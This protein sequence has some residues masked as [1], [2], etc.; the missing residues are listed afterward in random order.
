MHAHHDYTCGFLQKSPPPPNSATPFSGHL[1]RVFLVLITSR[2]DIYQQDPRPT[3]KTAIHSSFPFDRKTKVLDCCDVYSGLPPYTFSVTTNGNTILLTAETYDDMLS[4]LDAIRDCLEHQAHILRGVLWKKSARRPQQPWTQRDVELGHVS[5]TYVST[6]V[7]MEATRGHAHVFGIS[8]GES[9]IT[10]GAPSAEIKDKWLKEIEI[11]IAKQRIQRRVFEKPT[12]FAGFVDVRKAS[13]SKWRRRFVELERGALAFKTDQR[14]VGM[15]TRVPLE[16]ITA[17]IATPPV[18]ESG[19]SL[20]F[21]IERFGAVTL[22]LAAFSA[23]EKQ[24]WLTKL[25]MARRDHLQHEHLPNAPA[26]YLFPEAMRALLAHTGYRSVDV[27]DHEDLD[28]TIEQHQRRIFVVVPTACEEAATHVPQ[29]SVLVKVKDAAGTHTD[30][31]AMWHLLRVHARPLRLTFR[32]PIS[33]DGLLRVKTEVPVPQW[34]PRH[35][36]IADGTLSWYSIQKPAD[37]DDKDTFA[38]PIHVIRLRD[39]AVTLLRD[40]DVDYGDMPN[41]FVLSCTNVASPPRPTNAPTSSPGPNGGHRQSPQH[42]PPFSRVLFSASSAKECVLWISL[43]QVE[44]CT[45]RGEMAFGPRPPPIAER[46]RNNLV[47]Q[48]KVIAD[49]V[50]AKTKADD[51]VPDDPAPPPLESPGPAA[52]SIKRHQINGMDVEDHG[53]D[54]DATV[55]DDDDDDEFLT[56]SERLHRHLVERPARYLRTTT[57]DVVQRASTYA[58]QHR[59]SMEAMPL[60]R[61]LSE[62]KAKIELELAPAKEEAE[63]VAKKISE[64]VHET[65]ADVQHRIMI[66]DPET[67][68]YFNGSKRYLD[69]VILG[70]VVRQIE[71]VAR[72]KA[73][74]FIETEG[75]VQGLRRATVANNS[76]VTAEADHRFKHLV[77]AAAA[78]AAILTEQAARQFFIEVSGGAPKTSHEGLSRL[79]RHL[80]GSARADASLAAFDVAIDDLEAKNR[81]TYAISVDEFVA[82][83]TSTICDRQTIDGMA[84]YAQGVVMQI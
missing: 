8:S 12:D 30:F 60:Y 56:V 22:Y 81:L 42:S 71:H 43:L 25:D 63:K 38:P 34:V 83:A 48:V 72:K 23:S 27:A 75:I 24:T 61:R 65:L 49:K 55:D 44:I 51:A 84:R 36:V 45:F 82:V 69:A 67:S 20:A 18:D 33:K 80:A 52:L 59:Q 2:I 64:A 66:P 57:Q 77:A 58:A 21:A 46:R 19:R 41:C 13:K 9:T 40:I 50:Y 17:I 79:L 29:A 7:D 5:L 4:W 76:T 53:N 6:L 10:F 78:Q 74:R 73:L 26:T 37:T 14:K 28:M 35:C 62:A 11:R 47:K 68:D 32:L 16:L 39:C 15:S 31:D 70:T 1:T 3:F 54:P